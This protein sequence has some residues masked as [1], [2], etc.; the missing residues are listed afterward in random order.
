MVN[1]IIKLCGQAQPYEATLNVNENKL[2][3][4]KE[5]MTIDHFALD[6]P[7]TGTVYGTL[8]NYKGAIS[9]LGD[10]V[11]EVPYKK[12]PEAPILYMK[13]VNTHLA[14]GAPIPLPADV[15]ELEAGAALG[16]VIGQTA[17]RV[18]KASALDYIAGYTIAND[19]SVPHQSFYR[20]AIREKARDGFCP[21]GPWIVDKA[22]I[23]DPNNIGIRVY[24]NG[25][26]CQENTTA[27]H[28]RSVEELLAD[29]TAFM[30]LYPGDVLLTGVPEGA[31]LIGAYDRV[32]I[33]MDGVG[34][35]ENPVYPENKIMEG[36]NQ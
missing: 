28:I 1:G 4:H 9:K 3:L 22:A 34:A 33:E 23:N 6:I 15:Q 26:L 16:L 36:E 27:N 12:P 8:L 17:C 24:V 19:V 13:P 31:P 32:R 18:T 29:V 30:T 11:Y 5:W 25:V 21:I 35:L 20:P 2:K 10:A 7:I 14:H